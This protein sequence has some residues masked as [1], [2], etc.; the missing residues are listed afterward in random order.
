MDWNEC[1]R[2]KLIKKVSHDKYLIDSILQSS[3]DKYYS[4]NLIKPEKRTLSS[5][6]ILLYDSL[7]ELLEAFALNKG[8][9]IYNHECFTCFLNEI[10]DERNLSEVFD[11]LR[12]VRNGLNYY[13]RSLSHNDFVLIKGDIIFLLRSINKLMVMR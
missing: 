9:K 8:Y 5:I 13:G 6:I 2:K 11:K 4:S 3:R 1:Q 10:V 12:K 7:R